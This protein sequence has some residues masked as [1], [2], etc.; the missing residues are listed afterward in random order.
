M[1]KCNQHR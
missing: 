1:L